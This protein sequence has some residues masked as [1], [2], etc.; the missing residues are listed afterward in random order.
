M[1]DLRPAKVSELETGLTVYVALNPR[2]VSAK[3]EVLSSYNDQ[4]VHVR[5]LEKY[6]HFQKGEMAEVAAGMVYEKNY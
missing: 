4:V 6:C 5:F 1:E 3:A 2:K